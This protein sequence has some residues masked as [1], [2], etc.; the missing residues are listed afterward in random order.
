MADATGSIIC[1]APS[2]AAEAG[3]ADRVTGWFGTASVSGKG[4]VDTGTV[5]MLCTAAGV[6]SSRRAAAS[7]THDT[8]DSTGA[9]G[10]LSDI[11]ARTDSTTPGAA[12][13][14]P[15]VGTITGGTAVSDS[16]SVT[17]AISTEAAGDDA[18]AGGT[19]TVAGDSAAVG[20]ATG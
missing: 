11:G 20:N 1:T 7:I 9:T 17:G 8:A 10:P 14:G 6:P 4:P 13:D 15:G 3:M 18:V 12:A 5:G 19:A 2:V 16:G